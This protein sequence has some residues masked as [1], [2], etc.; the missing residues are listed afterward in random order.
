MMNYPLVRLVKIPEEYK[1]LNGRVAEWEGLHIIQ[2]L[3]HGRPVS[4]VFLDGAHKLIP[5]ENLEEVAE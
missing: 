5:N 3:A 4:M 2:T 1:Q